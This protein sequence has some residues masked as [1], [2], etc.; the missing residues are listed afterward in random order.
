MSYLDEE[1]KSMINEEPLFNKKNMEY[2]YNVGL[3]LFKKLDMSLSKGISE[4]A[5]NIKTKEYRQ[6]YKTIILEEMKIYDK[7][8]G[9]VYMA[10]ANE[11]DEDDKI[12]KTKNLEKLVDKIGSKITRLFF[13][14][15]KLM[16]RKVSEFQKPTREA[17][18]V[19]LMQLFCSKTGEI[20]YRSE[21]KTP[22][23]EL[24][25]HY[26]FSERKD[27]KYIKKSV[28]PEMEYNNLPEIELPLKPKY[29]AQLAG[30]I[31]RYKHGLEVP[32]VVEIKPKPVSKNIWGDTFNFQPIQKIASP[33]EKRETRKRLRSNSKTNSKTN[34][35]SNSKTN[36]KS[37]SKSKSNSNTKRRR[38]I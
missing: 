3:D 19:F 21:I 37:H 23:N 11:C 10:L 16:G 29:K 5:V 36:S 15:H 25:N 12:C 32:E 17:K 22:L 14:R 26:C 6:I 38:S 34:S 18:I 24:L 27:F 30:P 1:V 31:I 2:I 33:I 20:E 13:L 8:H 4:I 28:S 9:I 35:K 7:Y